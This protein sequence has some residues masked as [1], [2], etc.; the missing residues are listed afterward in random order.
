MN[1]L[2]K[3]RHLLEE[4]ING[5][6]SAEAM[7]L[8]QDRYSPETLK[9]LELGDALIRQIII[10]AT[11]NR[12]KTLEEVARVDT[13]TAN[14]MAA[15]TRR[16]AQRSTAKRVLIL[17]LSVFAVAVVVLIIVAPE[18]IT[19]FSGTERLELLPLTAA[20][21]IGFTL[22]IAVLLEWRS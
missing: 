17:G 12:L 5:T 15:S 20:G 1:Q 10:E 16:K 7:T 3:D 19:I 2:Q 4:L 13:I 6:I 22:I 9:N 11:A 14:I 21:M 8:L 18:W